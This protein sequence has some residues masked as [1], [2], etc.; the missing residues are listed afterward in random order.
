MEQV[1][2]RNKFPQRCGFGAE[3]LIAMWRPYVMKLASALKRVGQLLEPGA[4]KAMMTWP[5]FSISSFEICRRLRRHG[6][7]PATVIDVGANIG[8]FATA[9]WFEF[10][11]KR[12]IS[13]EPQSRC[14]EPLRRL[15]RKMP[16]LEIRQVALGETPGTTTMKLNVHSHSSSVLSLSNRHL[17]AFPGAV[18]EGEEQVELST[19]DLQF[20]RDSLQAPIL[21]KVDVQGY[22]IHVLRGAEQT[23]RHAAYVLLE[24]S[25]L[26]LY[27]GEAPFV[28]VMGLM[29]SRGFEFAG[30]VGFLEDPKTGQILQMDALFLNTNR[31]N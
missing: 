10:R 2:D 28:E 23:L 6:V 8:Q 7:V 20:A 27:E 25:F 26:P 4:L 19:L 11:P 18:E 12:V 3:I 30:A 13:F 17:E 16:G 24:T 15:S 31:V 22:E 14:A 5:T 1:R 29:S 9:S 21:L